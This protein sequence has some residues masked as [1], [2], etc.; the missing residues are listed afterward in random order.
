MDDISWLCGSEVYGM[1]PSVEDYKGNILIL[2][3]NLDYYGT[4]SWVLLK[5]KIVSYS[6]YSQLVCNSNT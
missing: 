2:E 5:A 4:G 1:L 6:L 3:Q